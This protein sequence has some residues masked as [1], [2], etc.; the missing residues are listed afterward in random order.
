LALLDRQL[1]VCLRPARADKEDFAGT[2][3]NV[4]TLCYFLER[5]NRN[6]RVSEVGDGDVVGR[7]RLYR[8]C[9]PILF[10]HEYALV[11]I[12]DRTVPKLEET[13]HG[14]H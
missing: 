2:E 3:G 14:F 6:R 7:G 1:A 10:I 11:S 4:L 13:Y 9:R 5:M 8:R 12:S